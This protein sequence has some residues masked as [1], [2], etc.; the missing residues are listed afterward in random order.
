MNYPTMNKAVVFL[1]GGTLFNNVTAQI[2]VNASDLPQGG[3]DYTFQNLTPDLLVDFG[4]TGPGWVWDF[5]DLAP[6]DSMIQE[7]SDI[8]SASF[9]TALVFNSPWDP[10][11]QADH[12]Y[13]F[14]A[15]PDLGDMGLPVDIESITGY[16]QVGDETY[17]QV[18]LGLM[19]SGFEVPV[20][21]EDVDEVHPV[22]LTVD[23]SLESTAAYVVDVPNTLYYSV[24]QTRES[25]VDG[26][27]TLMLPDGTSHDVLRLKSTVVSSDSVNIAA[28][29]QGL[30]F[31]RETVTYSWLGDGGMP[32][33]EVS[34]TFGIPTLARYQGSAPAAPD[35]SSTGVEMSRFAMR[36]AFP[37]PVQRG[38]R[39]N[40]QGDSQSV[41]T[42]FD[43]A[44]HEVLTFQGRS[45]ST[46]GWRSGLYVLRNEETG[47]TQRLVVE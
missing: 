10:D 19:L 34:T 38:A 27:G 30:A 13:P 36:A 8:S 44:G 47:R 18:G 33:M 17:T 16:H 20:V 29:G 37:N 3:S 12:Y 40:V 22:P 43:A 31:E 23:A 45:V 46:A 6:V 7:V 9:T 21:F 39:V 42:V 14:L 15:L 28:L 32:W 41:W 35:T 11:H 25:V 5:S 4:A 24:D 2:T 1:I 26:Y